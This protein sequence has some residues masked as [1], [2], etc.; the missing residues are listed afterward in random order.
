MD[1]SAYRS[2]IAV[3]PRRRQTIGCAGA[4]INATRAVNWNREKLVFG[5]A[6]A[7]CG[8]AWYCSGLVLLR[9]DLFASWFSNRGRLEG[10]FSERGSATG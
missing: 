1:F 8:S 4:Y 9:A 5:V 3:G 7:S 10:F 6:S 2:L